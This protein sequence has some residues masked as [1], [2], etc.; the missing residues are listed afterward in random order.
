MIFLIFDLFLVVISLLQGLSYF[1][2][3]EELSHFLLDSETIDV[4]RIG[5]LEVLDCVDGVHLAQGLHLDFDNDLDRRATGRL[6]LEAEVEERSRRHV[7]EPTLE[8]PHAPAER[9][10]GLCELQQQ[11]HG[12]LRLRA[13]HEHH[14]E[15]V[16]VEHLV[17]GRRRVAVDAFFDAA[18]DLREQA[19]L[20]LHLAVLAELHDCVRHS[21]VGLDDARQRLHFVERERLVRTQRCIE[22]VDEFLRSI[23]RVGWH[24]GDELPEQRQVGPG[25]VRSQS[26]LRVL[27]CLASDLQLPKSARVELGLLLPDGLLDGLE[28]SLGRGRRLRVELV[29]VVVADC[30]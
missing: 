10:P 5:A 14:A 21:L 17:E 26:F 16:A 11:P 15:S 27:D 29:D 3:F 8:P 9:G 6:Q 1:V 19:L 4:M 28:L 2:F 30:L 7:V 25:R 18:L 20:A 23:L 22:R 12:P 24:L 13:D